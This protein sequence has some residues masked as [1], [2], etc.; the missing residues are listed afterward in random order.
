M[1]KKIKTMIKRHGFFSTISYLLVTVIFNRVGFEIN[2]VYRSPSTGKNDNIPSGFSFFRSLDQIPDSSLV[3]IEKEYGANYIETIKRKFANEQVFIIGYVDNNVASTFWINYVKEDSKFPFSS[4][5]LLCSDYT[6][7][8]YRGNGLQCKSIHFRTSIIAEHLNPNIPILIES[9][10][11][12]HASLS[13]IKKAHFNKVG[14]YLSY[15]DTLLF[16][17]FKKVIN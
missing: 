7:P 2:T 17:S 14:S 15:R 6:Q 16:S 10:M 13:N 12:N 5:Y 3:E 9:S 11:T 1:I 4:Y 8:E